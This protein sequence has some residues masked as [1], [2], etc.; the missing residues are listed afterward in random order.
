MDFCVNLKYLVKVLR[1]LVRE[2]LFLRVLKSIGWY[3]L[4]YGFLAVLNLFYQCFILPRPYG[5]Y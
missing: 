4:S 5:F 1:L 3:G 2:F